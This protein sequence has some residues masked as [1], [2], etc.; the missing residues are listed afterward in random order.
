MFRS[1]IVCFYVSLNDRGN[2]M[3]VKSWSILMVIAL[4]CPL[5]LTACFDS[6]SSGNGD[7]DKKEIDD[8]ALDSLFD[9]LIAKVERMENAESLDDFYA[10]D[11]SSLT[12]GFKSMLNSDPSNMK[13]G[14]GFI[15]ASVANLNS[16]ESLKEIADS[17]DSYM[18]HEYW[19]DDFEVEGETTDLYSRAFKK[20][21]INGLGTAIFANSSKMMRTNA[22]IPAFP[23]IVTIGKIQSLIESEIMPV[24]DDV[25]KVVEDVESKSDNKLVITYDEETFEID[26]GEVY[27]ADASLRLLRHTLSFLT[28]YNYDI[29][30]TDGQNLHAVID[31]FMKMDENDEHI[32]RE[33]YRLSADGDTLYRDSYRYNTN[34]TQMLGTMYDIIEYNLG[35]TDFLKLQRSNHAK[36]YT[37]I[38]MVPVKIKK[39]IEFIKSESDSDSQEDDIIKIADIDDITDEMVDLTLD[40]EDANLSAAFIANFKSPTALADFITEILSGPYNFNETID[41]ITFNYTVDLS[42]FYTNP[43]QNFQDWFPLYKMNGKANAIYTEKGDA[44][45]SG[46]GSKYVYLN[47]GDSIAIDASFIESQ[48]GNTYML[49]KA[50][51][52]EIHQNYY[53][54]F[55][56]IAL[57][58]ESNN[59]IAST[60]DEV[61]ELF[62]DE[63]SFVYF[64]DYTF[65]GIFPDMTHAKWLELFNKIDDALFTEDS[66]GTISETIND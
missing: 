21:G 20:G 31:T 22:T 47:E 32:D 40:M 57:V 24:L 13:A 56:P 12:T 46:G 15:V 14:V 41:D 52:V 29:K 3:K 37:D 53:E 36:M 5:L 48:N 16:N 43:V 1:I 19:D 18:S 2:I 23:K 62:F 60:W 55:M 59:V 42:K 11:F 4:I 26:L 58:D 17:M 54:E 66:E 34:S 50:Y 49:K 61:E 9:S 27:L 64:K 38:K 63:T 28:A 30:F 10:E 33:V 39:A 65:N 8:V 25:I 45:E 35:R 7:G 51:S 6:S 44:W